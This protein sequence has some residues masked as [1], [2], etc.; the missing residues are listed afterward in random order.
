MQFVLSFMSS[1]A[2]SR[3]LSRH[4]SQLFTGNASRR[5]PVF[6]SRV[7]LDHQARFSTSTTASVRLGL[8]ATTSGWHTRHL[9][10][11]SVVRNEPNSRDPKDTGESEK[12]GAPDRPERN[13]SSTER[14]EQATDSR[15][16]RGST[17]PE[18]STPPSPPSQP[19]EQPQGP[20][21]SG[22]FSANPFTTGSNILDAF[23][24]TVIG[25]SMGECYAVWLLVYVLA[26]VSPSGPLCLDKAMP[27]TW[28]NVK[29]LKPA[30]PTVAIEF[31]A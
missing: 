10:S 5:I 9:S 13:V 3:T 24:T 2:S 23:I 14:N 26:N 28:R 16:S 25:L 31:V 15:A 18:V 21:G 19:P 20:Q 29:M 12:A 6:S 4:V 1:A 7:A 30:H 8:C 22:G 17:A 11:S 27:N